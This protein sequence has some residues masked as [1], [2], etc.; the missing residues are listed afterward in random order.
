MQVFLL[1]SNG[2]SVL[3]GN[4]NMANKNNNIRKQN[5]IRPVAATIAAAATLLLAPAVFADWRIEPVVKVAGEY[6]D[7]AELDTRTDREIELRGYLIEASANF[8]YSSPRTTFNALPRVLS[9]NYAATPELESTDLFLNSRFKHQMKSSSFGF[10]A[11]FDR[12]KVR[13]AE[14]AD[15]DLDVENP[16]DIPDDDSG[17]VG[18]R[19]NRSKWRFTPSWSYQLGEVSSISVEFDYFDVGYDDVFFG[20]LTDY[21]DGRLNLNYRREFS[22]RSAFLLTG[23]GRQYDSADD[24]AGVVNGYGAL[25]GFDSQLSQKTKLRV[26]IGV[27]NT[28]PTSGESLSQIVG[29]ITFIQR[30]ET[31][32]LLAQYRRSINASGAGRTSSRDQFN[33]NFT[34]RLNEK[35]SAGLGIRAYQSVGIGNSFA[36]DNRDY[37]QLRTNFIWHFSTTFQIEADYRYT[38]LDRG[39]TLGERANS[40]RISLWFVYLPNRTN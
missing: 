27:E 26:M 5:S 34:R 20:L 18:V 13:T 37:A 25:A 6:D 35:V 33:V 1:E 24:T 16:D 11:N 28:A 8:S 17:L 3:P 4:V 30:L 23:T 22:S 29:N 21:T 7:N 36:I 2:K 32:R 19:G 38:I 10:R 39:N 9:R 40:N 31:I 14:R 15:A 12:Q